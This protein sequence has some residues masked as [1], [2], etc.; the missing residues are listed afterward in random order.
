[1]I[2]P[3]LTNGSLK[4]PTCKRKQQYK[5]VQSNLV[6]QKTLTFINR[7]TRSKFLWCGKCHTSS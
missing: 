7:H 5:H 3:T 4:P 1:M 6:I 2:E